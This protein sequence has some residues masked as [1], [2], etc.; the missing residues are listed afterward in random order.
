MELGAPSLPIQSHSLR[1]FHSLGGAHALSAATPGARLESRSGLSCF[2]ARFQGGDGGVQSFLFGV[3]L[4]Q[5]FYDIHGEGNSEYFMVDEY[6][7]KIQRFSPA[8]S[9]DHPQR[10]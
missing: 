6:A 1:H 8:F 2:E 4:T 5:C 7:E 3:Q 9:P 10:Y